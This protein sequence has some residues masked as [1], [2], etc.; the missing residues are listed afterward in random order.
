MRKSLISLM[1]GIVSVSF[2]HRFGIPKRI[3]KT[4]AEQ[5]I[6]VHHAEVHLIGKTHTVGTVGVRWE[7]ITMS[8]IYDEI[9][10]YD[11][12][13]IWYKRK[14]YISLKRVG[15]M[16]DEQMAKRQKKGYWH[17]TDAYPHNLYCSECHAR[18]AQTHWAVW[19]DGSLPRNYCPN[20]GAKME[21]ER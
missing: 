15:E 18:F 9:E 13:H 1:E 6:F 5:W 7:E 16:V 19:E 8:R 20:C 4:Q 3:T 12:E 11:N 2:V 14:Q 10:I 21:V 17:I